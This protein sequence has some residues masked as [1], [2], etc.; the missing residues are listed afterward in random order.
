MSKLLKLKKWLTVDDAAQHL[1]IV[2][3]EKISAAD[4]LQLAL[5][6]KI[7]LSICLMHKARAKP[8]KIMEAKDVPVEQNLLGIRRFPLGYPKDREW[9]LF[10]SKDE[11]VKIVGVL[12]LPMIGLERLIIEKMY[13]LSLNGKPMEF[14]A[15]PKKG[16]LDNY[17]EALLNGSDGFNYEKFLRIE[18]MQEYLDSLAL[19]K[20]NELCVENDGQLYVL[21]IEDIRGRVSDGENANEIVWNEETRKLYAR[22]VYT[23]VEVF[24]PDSLL[25]FRTDALREFELSITGEPESA[26]KPIAE[27]PITAKER[28]TLLIIIAALAKEAKIDLTK[29]SKAGE[30]IA[31]L[32]ELIGAAVDHSTIEQKIKQIPNALESRNK[33]RNLT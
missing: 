5:D 13:L 27:K 20:S 14:S 9:K 18:N 15:P 24:P 3:G 28:N 11:I 1:S 22:Y 7:K 32:T 25:V 30:N 19:S 33:Q 2:I 10:V 26:E 17:E 8:A 23:N 31:H 16:E 4:L 21:Q 6:G 29:P 12:D